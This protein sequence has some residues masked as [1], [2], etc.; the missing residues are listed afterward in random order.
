MFLVGGMVLFWDSPILTDGL[1][2]T[3]GLALGNTCRGPVVFRLGRR[4]DKGLKLS[5]PTCTGCLCS[6]QSAGLDVVLS[7]FS[8]SLRTS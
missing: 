1:Q 6:R 8:A 3:T 5:F 2:T 4:G 7:S